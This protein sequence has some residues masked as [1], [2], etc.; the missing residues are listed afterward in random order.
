MKQFIVAFF[1]CVAISALINAAERKIAYD[2]SGKIFVVTS[3]VRIQRK[4]RTAP[5]PKFHQ[6][7]LA[8]RLTPKATRRIAPVLSVIL[9]LPTSP[10]AKSRLYPIFRA[11]IVSVLSGRRM[12][13]SSLSQS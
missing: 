13:N 10:A 9:Q 6:T 7:A 4:L 11:T 1:I 5:G 2:R 3:T 12:E 8:S